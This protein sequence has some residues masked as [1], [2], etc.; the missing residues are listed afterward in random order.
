M[1]LAALRSRNTYLSAVLAGM[2]ADR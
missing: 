2:P 1:F